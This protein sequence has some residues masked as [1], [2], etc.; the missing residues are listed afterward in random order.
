MLS[1]LRDLNDFDFAG[2]LCF[3]YARLVLCDLWRVLRLI[4]VPR[5][6]MGPTVRDIFEPSDCPL[7]YEG[8]F[9]GDVL[10][11]HIN[12]PANQPWCREGS[13]VRFGLDLRYLGG[14]GGKSV[15]RGVPSIRL[16]RV[17]GLH[18]C[19]SKM[20]GYRDRDQMGG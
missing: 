14:S 16:F 19:Q 2:W 7:A 10:V 15:R 11:F 9:H 1:Y 20:L 4:S 8:L 5:V 13:K 18:I 17:L 6:Q 12:L 3:R